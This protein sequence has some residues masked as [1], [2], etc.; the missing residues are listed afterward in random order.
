MAIFAFFSVLSIF[1]L[2]ETM[3]RYYYQ[4][5]SLIFKCIF[6]ICLIDRA[7]LVDARW[8]FSCTEPVVNLRRYFSISSNEDGGGVVTTV[9]VRCGN[10]LRSIVS[11]SY[12]S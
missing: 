4:R 1:L 12:S 5:P 7:Y 9:P 2:L 8:T 11:L 10:I 3:E 6:F